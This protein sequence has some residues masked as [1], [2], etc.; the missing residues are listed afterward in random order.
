MG[1]DSATRPNVFDT[2]SNTVG[3]RIAM[4]ISQIYVV[5]TECHCDA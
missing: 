4:L 1:L 3:T 5:T 2:A